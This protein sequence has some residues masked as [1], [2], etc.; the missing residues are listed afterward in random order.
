M[1]LDLHSWQMFLYS[2]LKKSNWM[3]LCRQESCKPQM[4][5]RTQYMYRYKWCWVLE[6]WRL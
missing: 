4:T 2:I 3:Y 6:R 5:L 1:N